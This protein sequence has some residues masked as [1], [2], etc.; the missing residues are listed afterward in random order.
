VFAEFETNLRRERQLEGIAKVKAA[1]VYKGRPAS[2]DAAQ[3]RATKAQG[4]AASEIAKFRR[5]AEAAPK[6][7]VERAA[8]S[9]RLRCGERGKRTGG[10]ATV[11]AGQGDA[12]VIQTVVILCRLCACG[13][14]GDGVGN[15]PISAP[16]WGNGCFWLR[17]PPS[18]T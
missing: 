17:L 13:P 16:A 4:K 9:R 6:R 18:R 15:G 1:G 8:G 10:A 11:P 14:T 7:R 12:A 2:M 5:I 3:V